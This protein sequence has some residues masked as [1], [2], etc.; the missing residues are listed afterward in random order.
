MKISANH[1][2]KKDWPSS[3]CK[4]YRW[5]SRRGVRVNVQY[6]IRDYNFMVVV[7]L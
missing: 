3:N 5:S 2:V 4:T 7:L 6:V 1:G